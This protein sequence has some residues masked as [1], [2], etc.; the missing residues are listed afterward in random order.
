MLLEALSWAGCTL[1]FC[2]CV[3]CLGWASV[4]HCLNTHARDFSLGSVL[5]LGDRG[6]VHGDR[7]ARVVDRSRGSVVLFLIW[8]TQLAQRAYTPGA[9]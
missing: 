4:A 8:K 5:P 3:L 9:R 1:L 2:F 7:E 6:G